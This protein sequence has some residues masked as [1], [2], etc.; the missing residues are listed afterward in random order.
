M[1]NQSMLLEKGFVTQL[2]NKIVSTTLNPSHLHVTIFVL[3]VAAQSESNVATMFLHT[4]DMLIL[5]MSYASHQ[6]FYN[7]SHQVQITCI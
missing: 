1:G 3:Q 4:M 2:G 5:Y 7:V 6:H